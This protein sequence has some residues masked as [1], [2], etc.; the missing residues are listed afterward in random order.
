MKEIETALTVTR[1]QTKVLKPFAAFLKVI[2]PKLKPKP[3][4]IVKNIS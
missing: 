1:T 2:E 4:Q 3:T